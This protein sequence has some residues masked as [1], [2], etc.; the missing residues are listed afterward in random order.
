MSA[1]ISYPEVAHLPAPAA[2]RA[3]QLRLTRAS[4]VVSRRT[5]WLHDDLLPLGT[6]TV[7]SGNSGIGKTTIVILWLAMVSN[8]TLPGEFYGTPQNVL[9]MSPEDDPAAITRPRLEA[10]GA[11]LDYVHFISVTRNTGTQEVETS[12]TFPQD[13]D[14]L[15]QAVKQVGAV[16]VLLDPIASLIDGNLDKREDVRRAFDPLAGELAAKH[17]LSVILIA[18]NKKGMDS[19]RG[20]ISGSGAITD[21]AR[22]VIVLAKDDETEK[23]ILSVDKSSYSTSEGTNLAYRLV[24]ETVAVSDGGTTGVARAEFLGPSDVSVADITSRQFNGGEEPDDRNEAERFI[25]DFL[26]DSGGE[27]LVKDI[28]KA[29]ALAGFSTATLRKARLRSKTPPI[30]SA[31]KGFGQGARYVWTMDST[32]HSMD[33]MDSNSGIHGI[34][35]ESM[36]NPWCEPFRRKS[37]ILHR[38]TPRRPPAP[39]AANRSWPP[40]HFR[41]GSALAAQKDKPNDRHQHGSEVPPVHDSAHRPAPSVGRVR[42]IPPLPR[43]H[44][45]THPREP[46]PVGRAQRIRQSP[47]RPQDGPPALSNEHPS[48][49]KRAR[50]ARIRPPTLQKSLGPNGRRQHG[51]TDRMRLKA[52]ITSW[53][54]VTPPAERIPAIRI[55]YGNRHLVIPLSEARQLSDQLHDLC[56]TH[57]RQANQ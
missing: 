15:H 35:E 4:D 2:P 53:S 9:I 23:I 33:S 54:F 49:Q 31:R 32:M 38:I 3:K 24:S 14:M 36:R 20:R 28:E 12:A 30:T 47:H 45:P 10:A 13:L 50:P 52:H 17:Q 18:H 41:P 40:H 6:I 57:E 46:R 19:N 8:G 26:T 48:D 29:G 44:R 43:A 1:A 16:A 7:V 51:R 34:H 21:A 56:D 55:K 27:A 22:S 42:T 5:K 39:D 25:V 11:N 37:P